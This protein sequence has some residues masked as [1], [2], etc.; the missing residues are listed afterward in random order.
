MDLVK[1]LI[2]VGVVEN[3]GTKKTGRYQRKKRWP[4]GRSRVGMTVSEFREPRRIASRATLAAAA[5]VLAAGLASCI[6][7]Q[8]R[9]PQPGA[10]LGKRLVTPH[11]VITYQK[12][13]FEQDPHMKITVSGLKQD[14]ILLVSVGPV[15]VDSGLSGVF[16]PSEGIFRSL[17]GGVTHVRGYNAV[18]RVTPGRREF[19]MTLNRGVLALTAIPDSATP[20]VP[21]G[22]SREWIVHALLLEAV[23]LPRR[24]GGAFPQ[25][26]P[27]QVPTSPVTII[28]KGRRA[29]GGER[30]PLI[31]DSGT[32]GVG[33]VDSP[34]YSYYPTS[35]SID[36]TSFQH[37]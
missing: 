19:D 14:A 2:K 32:L 31:Q 1:R 23:A 37:N 11:M 20:T 24:G 3:V 29:D 17:E 9:Q 36:A 22:R 28:E 8:S 15:Y 26:N 18:V 35:A 12:T 13:P 33:L 30:L 5:L 25:L 10:D 4:G 16:V 34:M 21:Y 7:T 27:G 6:P